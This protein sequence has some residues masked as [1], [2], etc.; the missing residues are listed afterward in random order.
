MILETVF[1]VGGARADGAVRPTPLFPS[2]PEANFHQPRRAGRGR[3]P[4]LNNLGR[5]HNGP[6]CLGGGVAPPKIQT[7]QANSRL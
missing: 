7:S 5:A 4:I 2:P 6:G 1:L 3:G